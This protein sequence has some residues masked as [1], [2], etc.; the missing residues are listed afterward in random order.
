MAPVSGY[1]HIEIIRPQNLAPG[2]SNTQIGPAVPDCSSNM[3]MGGV[4][5]SPQSL[6]PDKL[7]PI[8]GTISE[9]RSTDFATVELSHQ[10]RERKNSG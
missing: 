7:L 8:Q 5:L 4:S 6:K 9:G 3:P 2:A 10:P 1:Q